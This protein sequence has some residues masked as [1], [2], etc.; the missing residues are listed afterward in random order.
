MPKGRFQIHAGK[1]RVVFHSPIEPR[2]FMGRDELMRRVWEKINASLPPEYQGA[3]PE[4][5]RSDA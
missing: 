2:D 1:V 5:V 3:Y 4:A